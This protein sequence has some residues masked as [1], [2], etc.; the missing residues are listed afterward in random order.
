MERSEQMRAWIICA[1]EHQDPVHVL[2]GTE[3]EA[4]VKATEF[5]NGFVDGCVPFTIAI[6]P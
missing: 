2:I 3:A 6:K 5:E 4:E 1:E